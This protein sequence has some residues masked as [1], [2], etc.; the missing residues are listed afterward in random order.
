MGSEEL[1]KILGEEGFW[2]EDL[3]TF[4]TSTD[5]FKTPFFS[6]MHDVMTHQSIASTIISILNISI[7]IPSNAFIITVLA[8][9]KS[10]WTPS[11]VILA[12]NSLFQAIG[13]S[14]WMTMFL[15]GFPFFLPVGDQR[16]L[17]YAVGWWSYFLTFRLS[18]T[19]LVELI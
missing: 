9:T 17:L 8:K 13:S 7:I 5:A 3:C 14:V 12:V 1:F 10:L 2:D 19:R 15:V 18:C 16:T 6:A 11:N 4:I